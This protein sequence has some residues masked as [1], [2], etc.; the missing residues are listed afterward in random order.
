[1][2]QVK[3]NE[4]TIVI[5]VNRTPEEKKPKLNPAILKVAS[6]IVISTI[7][8]LYPEVPIAVFLIKLLFMLLESLNQNK[9]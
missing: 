9:N 1:M 4:T 7:N 2:K 6:F 8:W 5:V 3:Q